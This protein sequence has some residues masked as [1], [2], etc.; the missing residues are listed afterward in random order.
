MSEVSKLKVLVCGG[1]DYSRKAYLDATLDEL[2][3]DRPFSIVIH[4]AARGADTLAGEWA[5][6][7]GVGFRSY[8]AE[9]DK[10]GK[11]AGHIRNQR[12]LDAESPDL[13]VAFPGGRGTADM[14]ARARLAGVPVMEIE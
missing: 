3:A 7:R 13:V 14:V 4:G 9:W 11:S 6:T 1:R 2:H 12:M 8:P 5:V 10:Y